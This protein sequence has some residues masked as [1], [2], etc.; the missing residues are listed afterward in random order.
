MPSDL[1][2]RNGVTNNRTARMANDA[3]NSVCS[4][5]TCHHRVPQFVVSLNRVSPR[6]GNDVCVPGSPV[7]Q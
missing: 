1:V 7:E 6:G 3:V 5:I 4:S 2:L